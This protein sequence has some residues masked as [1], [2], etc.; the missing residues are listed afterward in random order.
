MSKNFQLK[1]GGL[2]SLQDISLDLEE[3]AKKMQAL[4]IQNRQLKEYVEKLSASYNETISNALN[5]FQKIAIVPNKIVFISYDGKGYGCNPKYIAEEILRR[6]LPLDLVWLVNDLKTP[7]PEKIR[8]VPYNL[9]ALDASLELSTAKVIVTNEMTPL[10]FHKKNN[11][12]LIMTWHACWGLKHVNLDR[13]DRVTPALMQAINASN[14]ITDLMIAGNDVNFAEI[15]RSFD[16][17]GEVISCGYPRQDLFFKPND[18]LAKKV[19]KSIGIP[20]NAKIILYAPT[21]RNQN[22]Q[23]LDVYQLNFQKLLSLFEKKFSGKWIL[24]MRLHPILSASDI[25][26]KVFTPSANI[27][28]VT[29]YPDMQELALISDVLLTDYSSVIYDFML[30]EKLTFI[31]AKDVQSYNKIQGLKDEFF[32]LP[33]RINQNEIELFDCIKNINVTETKRKLKNFIAALKPYDTGHA[34]EKVVDKIC[35]V[36]NIPT[37]N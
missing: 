7:L 21:F 8:R 22:P 12:Y 13:G 2:N 26:Q 19:R 1:S 29:K 4:Q 24:L 36:M 15:R 14:A 34:S 27:I 6:N 31:F 9:S 35:S 28:D 37:Q 33:F 10:P 5:I 25:S 20:S 16:Y 23:P 32:H 18:D 30:Q 3:F 17:K 11:Q